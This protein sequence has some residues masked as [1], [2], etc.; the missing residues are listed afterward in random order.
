LNGRV[1]AVVASAPLPAFQAILHSEK[2]FVPIEKTFTSEPIGF[3]LRKG[4]FDTLNFLD[5]WIRFV[6]A[7]GWLEQ[8][9]HYWFETRDWEN[10][11][12]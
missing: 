9:K 4:D 10:Q 3:A 11:I 6:Q 2:L 1:H 8:R 7:Q 12:K 5:N